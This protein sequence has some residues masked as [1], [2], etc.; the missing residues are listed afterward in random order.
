MGACEPL[1]F[2]VGVSEVLIGY[3]LCAYLGVLVGRDACGLLLC[4]GPAGM[5]CGGCVHV[6]LWMFVDGYCIVG[7]LACAWLSVCHMFAYVCLVYTC[8][9]LAE[10]N[11]NMTQLHPA[12]ISWE[13]ATVQCMVKDC[14]AVRP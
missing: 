5:C 2:R 14:S 11:N 7:V 9:Q 4:C 1:G 10:R 12:T 6:H 3:M 8:M 13:D